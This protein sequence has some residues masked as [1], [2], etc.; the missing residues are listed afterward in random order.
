MRPEL[1]DSFSN[2]LEHLDKP[3]YQG[4]VICAKG[5]SIFRAGGVFDS[6]VRYFRELYPDVICTSM[7]MR[8]R[9]NSGA[10]IGFYHVEKILGMNF[11][12]AMVL[13]TPALTSRNVLEVKTRVRPPLRDTRIKGNMW[14]F[15]I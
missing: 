15:E 12:S 1:R 3:E 5:S 9:F 2:F 13:V 8:I 6:A 4:A 11:S 10:E 7:P 14:L